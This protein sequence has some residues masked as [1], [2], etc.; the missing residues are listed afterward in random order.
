MYTYR[1]NRLTRNE[2]ADGRVTYAREF[3]GFVTARDN[4]EVGERARAAFP[5]EK[6]LE[7]KVAVNFFAVRKHTAPSRARFYN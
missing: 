5:D 7:T 3:L 1:V 4:I 6:H 2:D